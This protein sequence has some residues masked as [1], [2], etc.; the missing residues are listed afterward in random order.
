MISLSI[1][2][3]FEKFIIIRISDIEQFGRNSIFLIGLISFIIQSFKLIIFKKKI[4]KNK[5]FLLGGEKNIQD[6]KDFI[7]PYKNNLNIT[8]INL[9]RDNLKLLKNQTVLIFEDSSDPEELNYLYRNYLVLN[10]TIL[11]P[12]KFCEQYIHKIPIKY[13]SKKEYQ[14]NE[15]LIKT[16]V[17]Q[18]RFK[19]FG[20]IFVGFVLI[21]LTFPILIFSGLL[22]W[23]E[24]Q[25]PIFYFQIRTGLSGKEFK[26]IKLRTM[27]KTSE[28]NGAVWAKKNDE[29]ITNVGRFLRITRIDELP[30][31]ISVIIGDMS[32]IGPRPE[33]PEIEIILKK[34]IPFYDLR[35]S[36]KPGLSGW[37]QVNYPY[38]A[39]INDSKIKLSYD[40]FYIRNYS[41]FLDLLIFFKT[42]KLV[43]NMK[44]SQPIK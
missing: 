30:Q 29:R 19:R 1:I 40:L 32:L 4:A 24:D 36:I 6:F 11:T 17:F 44:G 16:D 31:L 20:D 8:F 39:S 42:I 12:C 7:S 10:L 33:R 13:L 28:E 14:L 21:T 23:I 9:S 37:A 25:G 18:W 41:F 35:H 43:L 5:I 2:Y 22:I 27:K 15:W 26:I 38:G 3:I 34:N